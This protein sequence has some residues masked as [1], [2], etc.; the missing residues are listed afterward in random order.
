MSV[1]D[2]DTID[3]MHNGKALRIRLAGVDAPEKTQSFGQQSKQYTASSCFHK[4]VTVITQ[5]QDR[6][7]RTIADIQLPDGALLSNEL[8]RHGYAWWYRKYAPNNEVLQNLEEIARRDHTGLWI[9][10]APIPPWEYRHLAAA[11]GRPLEG[12]V[13]D[14]NADTSEVQQVPVAESPRLNTTPMA[15][16]HGG[17]Q[18]SPAKPLQGTVQTAD[19]RPLQGHVDEALAPQNTLRA[20]TASNS[21]IMRII[22][23]KPITGVL[24]TP[25]LLLPQQTG[26]DRA[27]RPEI[28]TSQPIPLRAAT[29]DQPPSHVSL[30]NERPRR[31]EESERPQQPDSLIARAPTRLFGESQPQRTYTEDSPPQRLAMNVEQIPVRSF[32]ETARVLVPAQE[33]SRVERQP[34]SSKTSERPPKLRPI[35]PNKKRAR[36]I[37]PEIASLPI[38]QPTQ[39][40]DETLLWDKWYKRVNELVCAALSKTMPANGNPAG[41]NRIHITVWP[42]H[43]IVPSLIEGKTPNFNRAVLD[44]Y[45]MLDGNPELEF[46]IG[47]HRS[48]NEYETD[49]IQETSATT[50]VFDSQTIHGDVEVVK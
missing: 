46:P 31:S 12:H 5:G 24:S 44:A 11:P 43:K 39:P 13:T 10:S 32:P 17:V 4:T 8:V 15:P 41:R 21:A 22:Q 29:D 33:R 49:H 40:I 47:T 42:N 34:E 27:P 35:K 1:S 28:D 23:Y 7:R 2:G 37:E 19:I 20:G 16:L 14:L 18:E 6:Y 38:P 30:L 36:N 45:K 48:V 26:I 3:V 50:A 9:D 25:P